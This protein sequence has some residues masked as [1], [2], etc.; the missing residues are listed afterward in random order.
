MNFNSS[1]FGYF[2]LGVFCLYWFLR[3]KRKPRYLLL[4]VASWLFYASWKW[5]FLSLI[6]ISTV[7][8]FYIGNKLHAL[9]PKL[10]RKRKW[11]LIA[12][13]C[14]NLGLLGVF[15]YYGFFQ[16]NIEAIFGASLPALELIL[17]VGISFYTFQT[18]SYTIDIYRG[19]LKP[20]K[21]FQE[22]ALFV[23]FFPQLVAGPIVRASHF[24][25][26]LERRPTL[27][28]E[29][30]MQGLFRIMVGLFKKILI[31][32]YIAVKLV[33][34]VFADNSELQGLHVL[35]GIYGFALQ[36]YGDFS[37]YSDIA[38][39]SAQLLGFNIP[40][41]F[42]R[43]YCARSIQDFW[44]RWHISLS[45]WLR[46]YL[47]VPLGGNRK[48]RVRT[49]VNLMLTMLL[50]GLWH[51]AAWNFVV[52]GGLHG[53]CLAINRWWQRRGLRGLTGTLGSAL[54]IMLTF[55]FVCITWVFFRAK[56]LDQAF[57]VFGRLFSGGFELPEIARP[58]WLA[59]GLGYLIHLTPAAWR[60]RVQR[61]YVAMPGF[62]TGILW[63][64]F[65][66]FIA[67]AGIEGFPFIYFQF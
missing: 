25:P 56:T 64:L 17:P 30:L 22:F 58:I 42:A 29:A 24:L 61:I 32:D 19:K 20:A 7:L 21:S 18:L 4:L 27:T 3:D 57:A 35:L 46:D 47:Y 14:G 49:Y 41:N 31:A 5:Q 43:P 59:L 62:L 38:I 55:H 34:P 16:A 40:E 44:R 39:G 51:G 33:E 2:L 63:A 11:L 23:A 12:S 66:G 54:S 26:Q 60:Q 65:L 67:F 52:W 53:V 45:S 15:K 6:L 36:I 50:G 8:D 9:D 13:L 28:R 1:D 48:G 37:G 10:E